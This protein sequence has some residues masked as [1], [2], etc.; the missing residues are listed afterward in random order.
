MN[1]LTHHHIRKGFT[2]VEMVL[3]VSLCSI[4]LLSL[5]TFLS[6][7]LES[8]VRS[9]S[10]SE[11]N[12]QGLQVMSLITQTIRNGR[13]IQTPAIGVTAPTLSITTANPLLNPTVFLLSS[14]TLSI[15]EAGKQAI[16][17]TNSRVQ[18]SALVFQNIS[19]SSSTEKIIRISFT[20]DSR[21]PQGRNE[22]AFTKT[23][24]GSATL[25]Q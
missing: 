5:S 23:F 16:P 14:T 13:S 3:Y 4:I 9:Q 10:I 7:L 12:Q 21:N 6:F 2:L 25:R 11:V 22:Y 17:L 8:R 15:Q 19:S 20:L 24:I 18:V 1:H